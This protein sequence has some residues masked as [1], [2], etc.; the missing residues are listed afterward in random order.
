MD[1]YKLDLHNS[2]LRF[3][4]LYGIRYNIISNLLQVPHFRICTSNYNVVLITFIWIEIH[5]CFKHFLP[6]VYTEIEEP[7]INFLTD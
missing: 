6:F 1:W 3:N 4:N 5:P 2:T 7:D